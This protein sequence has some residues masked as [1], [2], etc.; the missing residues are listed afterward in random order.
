MMEAKRIILTGGP[1]AGKS[2]LLEALRGK[3]FAC[4]KEAARRVIEQ[5]YSKN[6]TPWGDRQSFLREVCAQ[7]Q[8]DL[9]EPIHGLT[10]CDRG[11]PDCLAYAREACLPVPELLH[12]FD[13]FA[14]YHRQVF[15][16][17]PWLQIYCRETARQQEF[18]EAVSLYHSIVST[19]EA[20]GFQLIEVPPLPVEER[21]AFVL[22]CLE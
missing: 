12:T 10:F 15:V 21:T 17:P 6:Y 19:Y 11:M 2:S 4:R 14:Y 3:G 9:Q 20:Y 8:K 18:T 22:R 16:L 13:P 5:H 1:G 7:I